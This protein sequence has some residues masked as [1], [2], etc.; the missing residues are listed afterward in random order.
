MAAP[1]HKILTSLDRKIA[2]VI[3]TKIATKIAMTI[4]TIQQTM[5]ITILIHVIAIIAIA[6][7]LLDA[8]VAIVMTSKIEITVMM[9]LEIPDQLIF[10][11]GI[12]KAMEDHQIQFFK[13]LEALVM[14]H[15]DDLIIDMDAIF[16]YLGQKMTNEKVSI[17][18][19]SITEIL[20]RVQ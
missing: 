2:T 20:M 16:T 14:D 3:D 4:V 13:T 10:S 11:A 17:R 8:N 7:F 19:K 18:D 15:A 9:T 1:S 12:N 6:I 5:I